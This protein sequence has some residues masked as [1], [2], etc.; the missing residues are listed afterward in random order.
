MVVTAVFSE[1]VTGMGAG[2]LSVAGPAT[3]A[4]IAGVKLMP[5]TTTYYHAVVNL[6]AAYWGTVSVSFTVSGHCLPAAC[7]LVQV[8]GDL[9]VRSS[10][11]CPYLVSLDSSP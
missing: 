1:P 5:G 10:L 7:G 4:S 3:G 6:P 2:S 9:L 8:L 11:S